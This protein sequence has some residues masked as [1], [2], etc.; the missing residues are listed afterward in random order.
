MRY[1]LEHVDG[2]I[3]AQMSDRF[4]FTD[5]P[6]FRKMLADVSA[7]SATTIVFDLAKLVFIDSAA[8]GML[9]IG[10]D[11]LKKINRTLVLSGPT[12]QVQ[13]TLSM[14]AIDRMVRIEPAPG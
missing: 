9:L 7:A 2:R 12:G 11:E 14:A 8:L 10:V 1:E 13:R 5:H 3:I 4:T 6:T